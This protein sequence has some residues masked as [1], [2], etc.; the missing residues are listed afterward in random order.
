VVVDQHPVI[1]I[2][3][4]SRDRVIGS[5]NGMPWDVPEEYA[6]FLRAIDGQTVILGRRSFEIFGQ[7][8]TSAHTIV[9]SCSTRTLPDATVVPSVEAA[10]TTASSLGGTLFSAGGA[11]I[12]AQTL[13]LA[14]AMQLSFIK[15][16]FTGDAYFPAWS[17]A[18]WDEVRREE[19]ARY[20][21]VEYRRRAGD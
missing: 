14:N 21:F 20:T 17:E 1:I 16:E 13:P 2:G 11:S 7:G 15:G 3:A 19:H 8:L 9:V 6:H 5:G 10:V 4:M 12:Y 18:E